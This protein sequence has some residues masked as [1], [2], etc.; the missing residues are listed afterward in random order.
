MQMRE[1]TRLAMEQADIIIF[2][3]DGRDGLTPS[4]EEIVRQLRSQAARLLRRQ[5]ARRPRH[6]DNVFDFY[7]LGRAH[8]HD[9]AEHGAA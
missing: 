6:D 1:Q 9:L 2:L 7:R 5:Q 4:D 3:M 8:L